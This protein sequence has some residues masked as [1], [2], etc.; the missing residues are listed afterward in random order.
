MLRPD[1][2]ASMNNGRLVPPVVDIGL[3]DYP[4][5]PV[6][7]VGAA[8]TRFFSFDASTI[9]KELGNIWLGKTVMLG[10]ISNHLPFS[11]EVLEQCILKRFASK[12]SELIKLNRSA[13]AAGRACCGASHTN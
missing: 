4:D 8:G 11:A 3:Y 10:A 2:L 6:A 13:F 7:E 1:R 5:D 12:K 9:A